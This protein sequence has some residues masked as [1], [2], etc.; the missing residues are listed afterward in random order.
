[1]PIIEVKS[2]AAFA[3]KISSVIVLMNL[4]GVG[5]LLAARRRGRSVT[6]D[7]DRKVPV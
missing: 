4:V 6:N 7:P 3:F 5:I 2:A 1:V